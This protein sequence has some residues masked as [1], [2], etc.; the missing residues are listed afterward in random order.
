MPIVC[1]LRQGSN[2]GTGSLTTHGFRSILR[3]VI[4]WRLRVALRWQ[5]D[6]DARLV[7]IPAG[8]GE[9]DARRLDDVNGVDADARSDVARRRDVVPRHVDR[10]DGRDDAA[11]PGP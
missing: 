1:Y 6:A 7:R 10:D 9:A 3:G 2:H 4:R 11:V 5:H 8:D